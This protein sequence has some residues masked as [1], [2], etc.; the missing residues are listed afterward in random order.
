MS[1]LKVEYYVKRVK[2]VIFSNL[3]EILNL[4]NENFDFFNFFFFFW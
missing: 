2:Y 4:N 3:I 1:C